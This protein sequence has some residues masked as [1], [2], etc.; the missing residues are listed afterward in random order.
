M[1]QDANAWFI[2]NDEYSRHLWPP[3]FWLPASRAYA[4]SLLDTADKSA[5]DG[6]RRDAIRA[7]A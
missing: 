6:I 5:T 1:E 7:K 3:G 2:I 4:D